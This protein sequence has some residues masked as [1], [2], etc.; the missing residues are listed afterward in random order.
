M[1]E[2]DKNGEGASGGNGEDDSGP[3]EA[4][5]QDAEIVSV[6]PAPPSSPGSILFAVSSSVSKSPLHNLSPDAQMAVI[7]SLDTW[8]ER[9]LR[10]H[11][12]RL[13]KESEFQRLHLESAAEGRKQ[14]LGVFKLLALSALAFV[15]MVT[16]I[17]LYKDQFSVAQTVIIASMTFVS[18]LVGGSALPGLLRQFGVSS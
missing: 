6:Q 15:A 8:D 12:L 1:G 16:C 7:Q 2:E 4:K 11:S 18:G 10:Y 17:L 13:E 14:G 9:Q 5:R 3:E